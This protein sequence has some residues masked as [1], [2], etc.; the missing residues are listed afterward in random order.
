MAPTR[1][2][3]FTLTPD[4]LQ[5]ESSVWAYEWERPYTAQTSEPSIRVRSQAT[6]VPYPERDQNYH[7][8]RIDYYL[9]SF[10]M[11][12]CVTVAYLSLWLLAGTFLETV[13]DNNTERAVHLPERPV[14]NF[15]FQESKPLTYLLL[16]HPTICHLN[17]LMG[18]YS[19]D[20]T[21]K[22]RWSWARST[23]LRFVHLS[24][25]GAYV[26]LTLYWPM[27]TNT[28]HI[29]QVFAGAKSRTHPVG[30]ILTVA[31]YLLY[32]ISA[33]VLALKNNGKR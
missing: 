18:M 1:A 28:P 13:I 9:G 23:I 20:I 30:A 26:S 6:L 32:A 4:S 12:S 15:W 22:P 19:D 2:S 29:Y 11:G 33:G 27:Y 10:W 7:L 21:P 14:A 3:S 8:F 17:I 25:L 16:Y 5:C 24:V 31:V